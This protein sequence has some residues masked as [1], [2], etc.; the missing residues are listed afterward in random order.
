MLVQNGLKP[1]QYFELFFIIKQKDTSL[2]KDYN[3]NTKGLKLV[4]SLNLG[5]YKDTHTPNH[6]Q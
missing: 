2:V 5:Y 3:C 6:T 4:L 1:I